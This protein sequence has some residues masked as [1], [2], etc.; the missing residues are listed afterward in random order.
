[1]V[2]E[3]NICKDVTTVTELRPW[4]S[5]TLLC[6]NIDMRG[7][8]LEFKV[9]ELL[10]EKVLG[11]TVFEHDHYFYLLGGKDVVAYRGTPLMDIDN[12]DIK[13]LNQFN[14]KERGG[15]I[16]IP[17]RF[18]GALANKS[19]EISTV[20]E[21]SFPARTGGRSLYADLG[22]DENSL[23]LKVLDVGAGQKLSIQSHTSRGEF[24][25][26][27]QGEVVAYVGQKYDAVEDT[28][29]N[30]EKVALSTG[31]SL[32]IP[33]EMVHSLENL[34]GK[35]AQVLELSFGKYDEN[36]IVRYADRYG[37]VK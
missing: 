6:S 24:W 30:L 26:V 32:S 17:K 16:I 19:S 37:R 33:V 35:T 14:L 5:Y 31:S 3:K 9:L 1:M 12:L 23:T 22:V 15:N 21:F 2:Q 4:G 28:V 7:N 34:G 20:L 8:A 25:Y 27:L 18:P 29:R 13:N 10:S 36:D 11:P